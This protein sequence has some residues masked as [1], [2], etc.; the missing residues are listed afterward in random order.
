MALCPLGTGNEALGWVAVWAG[1]TGPLSGDGDARRK[2]FR[3]A[4]GMKG[5]SMSSGGPLVSQGMHSSLKEMPMNIRNIVH[6]LLPS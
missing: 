5:A 2:P 4:V 3:W 1:E 6:H